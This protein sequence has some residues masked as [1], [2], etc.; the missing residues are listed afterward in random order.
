MNEVSK[1]ISMGEE[2]NANVISFGNEGDAN[3]AFIDSIISSLVSSIE[4][5]SSSLISVNFL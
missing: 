2:D 1:F 4:D 5:N 3:A